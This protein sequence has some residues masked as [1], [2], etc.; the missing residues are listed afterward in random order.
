MP[1]SSKAQH[2]YACGVASGSIKGDMPKEVA[3]EFCH[4][5]KGRVKAMPERLGDLRGKKKEGTTWS[6]HRPKQ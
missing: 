6:R 1:S 3:R 5:D 4:A 2:R